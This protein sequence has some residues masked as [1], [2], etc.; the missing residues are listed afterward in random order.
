MEEKS[1]IYFNTQWKKAHERASKEHEKLV[2]LKTSLER[3]QQTLKELPTKLSQDVMVPFG[4][5]AFFPGKLIHTNEITVLLGGEYYVETT[6][7]RAAEI[8][9][10]RIEGIADKAE[11]VQNHMDNL[12]IQKELSDN[13]GETEVKA[14]PHLYF[15]VFVCSLMPLFLKKIKTKVKIII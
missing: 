8:A 11:K 10:R 13:I 14:S 4:K 15:C 7:S 9:Q 12:N 3:T 2:K 6:A 5:L 1:L